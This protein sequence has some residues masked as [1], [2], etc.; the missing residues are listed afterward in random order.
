[1]SNWCNAHL[2]V[3]GRRSAVLRFSR[4]SR[5]RPSAL[6]GLYM[7]EGEGGDLQSERIK[8]LEPG[9]ATKE[10]TFQIC[11]DD[12]RTHFTRLSRQ[13]PTLDFV[14]VFFDPNNSPICGS[15]FISRGRA[16]S[17][18][19]P[20]EVE[21]AVFAKH[22]YTEDSNDDDGFWEA[23]WELEELA[24]AHWQQTLIKAIHR[25]PGKVGRNVA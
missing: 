25:R 23:S 7:L 6:F 21:T 16:R 22:G 13:F 2:I 3:A 12:G 15:F 10:Y 11:N 1:M 9:F 19:V 24:K 5:V 20:E 17:Y 8:T 18:V 4:L 14:V